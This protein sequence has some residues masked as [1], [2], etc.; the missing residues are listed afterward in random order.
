MDQLTALRIFLRV[1]EL[2]SFSKAAAALGI[3]KSAV[4]KH[5]TA[6]E[7]HLGARLLYR[8]TRQVSL[9]EEGQSYLER[10]RRILEDID[11]ADQAVSSLKAEPRGTLRVNCALVY[12]LRHV[13]PLLPALSE[14]YPDLV[15]DLEFNDR[16]VDLVEEGYDV[17]IRIGPL[18][19]SSLIA[20]KIGETR[21]V[22]VAS[23]AYL[24]G[25]GRPRQPR[26]LGNHD[27]LLYRGRG[28]VG[29]WRFGRDNGEEQTARIGGPVITNNGEALK[30]AAL[31]GL[32]IARLPS[33]MLDDALEAGTLVE[34]LADWPSEPLPIQAV[35]APNRHLSAKVR[36]F[37]DFLVR[38][39]SGQ[40]HA[41]DGPKEAPRRM[42]TSVK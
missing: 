1:A 8:T 30:M 20:R 5:L 33:F 13:A 14:R 18:P 26:D 40:K 22:L 36:H 17:A 35:Y 9:S 11:E 2:N 31:A 32:G 38:T 37:I 10:A 12:G 42:R 7:E 21:L 27:C 24:A 3:S 39:F 23:P 15:I 34:L 41:F 16:Y 29:E 4:S 6:L 25:C 28:G 19:D